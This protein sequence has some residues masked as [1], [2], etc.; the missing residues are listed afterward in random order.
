MTRFRRWSDAEKRI[1][2][3]A[4]STDAA[5]QALAAAGYTR[6]VTAVRQ[7]RWA[8][9]PNTRV[10]E[11]TQMIRPRHNQHAAR[12]LAAAI[13]TACQGGGMTLAQYERILHQHALRKGGR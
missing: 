5:V 1:A 4:P 11:W 10:P 2:R 9:D 13:E 3:Q 12:A 7:F 6:T 8:D